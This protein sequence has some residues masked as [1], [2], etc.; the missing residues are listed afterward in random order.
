MTVTPKMVDSLVVAGWL[1]PVG[2]TE[3]V[4]RW[5]HRVTEAGLLA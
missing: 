5:A 1:E 2:Y 4:E 3:K